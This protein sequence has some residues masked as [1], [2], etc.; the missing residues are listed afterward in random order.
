[1][2]MQLVPL[3]ANLSWRCAGEKCTFE[4]QEA[5]MRAALGV[6]FVSDVRSELCG[7]QHS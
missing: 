2:L 4:I 5:S 7:A 6:S 3:S 1:M